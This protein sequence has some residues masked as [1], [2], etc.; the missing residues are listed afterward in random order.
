MKK[1]YDHENAPNQLV[2]GMNKT[3]LRKYFREQLVCQAVTVINQISDE[4]ESDL[5]REMT[6]AEFKI[7]QEQYERLCIMFG[8]GRVYMA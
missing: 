8:T 5:N 7:F 6:D 4:F 2:E 3:E 1:R